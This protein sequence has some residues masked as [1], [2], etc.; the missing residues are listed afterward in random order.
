MT[1]ATIRIDASLHPLLPSRHR[2]AELTV[3]ADGVATV[4]HAVES[5]GLPRTEIGP[6][7]VGGAPADPGRRLAPGDVVGVAPVPRPQPMAFPRFVLDVHFGTLAR[8]MRLL[9]IDTAYRN[10]AD[11]PELVEQAIAEGRILLTQDRGLLRRRALPQGALIPAGDPD[12]QLADVLDRFAPPLAPWTRCPACNG[13][14]RPVA[15]EAVAD[16]LEPGTRDA[17]DAFSQCA[18]CARVYWRGAHADRLDAVV[19]AAG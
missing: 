13:L 4:G 18:D 16:R 14:L 8:R 5:L 6:V 12:A 15:K 9:G 10:D 7:T 17:F 3:P 11:D 2:R 1:T 19:T